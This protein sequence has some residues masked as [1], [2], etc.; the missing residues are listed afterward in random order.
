MENIDIEHNKALVRE[1]FERVIN[2]H[3]AALAA[4]FYAEDYIQHNPRVPTGRAGLQ[5][6]LDMMFAGIPDLEGRVTL[7]MAEGDRVMALVEWSGTHLGPFAGSPATGRPI[8]F[9]SAEIFRVRDGL[10][11][12]HWDV[13]EWPTQGD[14][15]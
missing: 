7:M 14:T 4:A 10:L 9:K 1:V 3:D 13:V 12:E 5:Q 6:L 15:D 11:T 2:G 8:R